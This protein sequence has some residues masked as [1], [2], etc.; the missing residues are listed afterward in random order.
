[1]YSIVSI[2]GK[3][4]LVKEGDI[5]E[6]YKLQQKKG[7]KFEISDVVA[8]EKD[9]RLIMDKD[10]LK[11]CK[12]IAEVIKEKKGEKIYSFKK[13]SKTGYKRGVGY[14]DSVTVLK[15]SQIIPG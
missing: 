1:M 15:I 2:S 7:E 10:G 5:L 13:K 6:V 9:G 11:N 8:L 4:F 3:Q 14:R 12:V